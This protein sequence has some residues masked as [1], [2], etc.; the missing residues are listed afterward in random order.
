MVESLASWLRS[1]IPIT[2]ATPAP[3]A[4]AHSRSVDASGTTTAC[5]WSS[6]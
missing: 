1:L 4:A 5:A 2:T 6:A 3:R